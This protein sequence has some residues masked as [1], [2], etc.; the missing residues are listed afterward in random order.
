[1]FIVWDCYG[2]CLSNFGKR[3]LFIYLEIIYW[4]VSDCVIVLGIWGWNVW[5]VFLVLRI[6]YVKV[7]WD[8][9]EGIFKFVWV[10]GEVL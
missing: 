7:K 1:M 4:V 3:Y 5:F 6:V 9:G 2:I 8:I 10:V